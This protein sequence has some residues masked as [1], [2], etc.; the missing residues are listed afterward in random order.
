MNAFES[1]FKVVIGEEGDFSN[2]PADPGNWTSGVCGQGVC[3]G[4]R[5]GIAAADHPNLDIVNLTLGMARDIYK[6]K[7]WSTIRGN[8]LPSPLALLVFDAAV[9]CGATRSIRWLQVAAQC[10]A[11][12]ILGDQT[13]AA[14]SGKGVNICAEFQAQRL[15]WMASL[16]T[17]R[18][19]GLGWA[20]RIC[21][22]AYT[23]ITYGEP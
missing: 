11:D 5:Y 2:N 23:S 15:T 17:W 7:Y 1:A 21:S 9:N 10:A 6:E 12:G 14:A 8:D 4:T 19:F 13:I 16:P 18:V 22:L 20:R 3:R